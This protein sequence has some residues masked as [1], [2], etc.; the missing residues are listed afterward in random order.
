MSTNSDG[1]TLLRIVEEVFSSVPLVMEHKKESANVFVPYCGIPIGICLATIGTEHG[2]NIGL[3]YYEGKPLIVER[4]LLLR[5]K[6]L[7]RRRELSEGTSSMT[8][9]CGLGEACCLKERTN[10]SHEIYLN[11]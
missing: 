1:C 9:G 8:R 7:W 4:K 11:C 5:W 10:K 3:I 6:G 2:T